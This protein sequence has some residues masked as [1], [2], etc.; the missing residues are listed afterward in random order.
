MQ[1]TWV[2]S[3]IWE[4]P[5]MPWALTLCATPLSL[6]SRAQGLPLLKPV[7]P[8]A[9]ALH[10]E[11]PAVRSL[12]TTAGEEPLLATTRR[13][14]VYQQRPSTAKKE[15]KKPCIKKKKLKLFLEVNVNH[16]WASSE[17][18]CF[19]ELQSRFLER[20]RSPLGCT[21]WEPVLPLQGPPCHLKYSV[22][23]LYV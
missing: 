4:D 3:Q 5:H 14:H 21:F 2:W 13:K 6:Y 22:K 7:C 19:V 12:C 20:L 16:L 9:C 15:K 11:K 1:K 23:W 10:H 18:P 17:G 8:R